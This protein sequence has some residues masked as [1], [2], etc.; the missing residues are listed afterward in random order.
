[1]VFQPKG[2][3]WHGLN[4]K[5]SAEAIS[6]RSSVITQSSEHSRFLMSKPRAIKS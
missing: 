2:P 1:M 5:A 3:S 4:S 6:L